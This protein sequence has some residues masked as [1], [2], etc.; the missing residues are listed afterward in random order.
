MGSR[1]KTKKLKIKRT[2]G[3][4][5]R[6]QN[7]DID[8]IEQNENSRVVY[9]KSDLAEM[10]HSLKRNG[11][12]QPIGVRPLQGGRYDCIFGNRRL[13][14]ARLCGWANIDAH[15]MHD[16]TEEKDRDLLGL[17]E[18]IKK[19]NTTPAEEGRIYCHLRD[20][21][22]MSVGEIAA[23]L[24]VGTAR[25]ETAIGVYSEIPKEYRQRVVNKASGST[26]A[27]KITASSAHTI[28]NLKKTHTLN[29]SQTK[30]LLDYSLNGNGTAGHL[31]RIA[32]LIADGQSVATAIESVST[33]R[34]V[35]IDVF[36]P[37]AVAAKLE[38]KHKKSIRQILTDDLASN[39]EFK[40]VRRAQSSY[41]SR[42]LQTRSTLA[43]MSEREVG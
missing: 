24:D 34:R 10:V 22:G 7:I 36:L 13:T 27:G 8:L 4:S 19:Q 38:R 1:S 14:A 29:E 3:A 41:Q 26:P 33:L 11:L 17:E 43:E 39:P 16:V 15:I 30:A 31:R 25:V 18:N 23:R 12:L 42:S 40:I 35:G 9:K 32:P 21:H 2:K 6:V 20:N 37:E 5:L 28:L